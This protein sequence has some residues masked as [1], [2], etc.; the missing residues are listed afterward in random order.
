MDEC[1]A[2]LLRLLY[3]MLPAYA[4]NMAPPFSRYWRHWNRPIH[5]RLL[6]RHKTVVGFGL[7]VSTAVLVTSVQAWLDARQGASALALVDYAYWPW[8]GLGFGIGAMAGDC[9]KSLF[10]RR[11]RIAPGG[12][13]IPFDQIDFVLGALALVGPF[14]ALS[15]TDVLLILVVSFAGDLLVNRIAFSIGIKDTPW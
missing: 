1:F 9:A 4:A 13:W 6:G 14:A 15:W 11:L 2:H 8:L 12:R 3:F 10:K 5:E 7:G